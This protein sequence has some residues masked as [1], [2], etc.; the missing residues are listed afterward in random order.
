MRTI[1]LEIDET[2]YDK[3]MAL[4]DLIPKGKVKIK[5]NIQTDATMELSKHF[6]KIT[7]EDE[8]L[9]KKLAQ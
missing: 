1:K 7:S 2:V 9:L 6:D 5:D 4:L 8:L 3:F